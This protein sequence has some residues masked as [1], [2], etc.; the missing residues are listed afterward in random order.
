MRFAQESVEFAKSMVICQSL[1]HV[2]SSIELPQN[3]HP[4]N[5]KL[6]AI[7]KEAQEVLDLAEQDSEANHKETAADADSADAEADAEADVEAAAAAGASS[8][9]TV[10]T[11]GG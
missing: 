6:Q 2:I 11:A 10:F 8:G 5:L 7:L 1:H 3:A 9:D 4:D